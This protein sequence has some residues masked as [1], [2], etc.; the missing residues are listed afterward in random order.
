[1][2]ASEYQENIN[3]AL[4]SIC[5]IGSEGTCSSFLIT[6]RKST[7]HNYPIREGSLARQQGGADKA[8][9]PL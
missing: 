8:Y 6:E 9:P 2:E 5:Q 3:E 7:M 1:M 4:V